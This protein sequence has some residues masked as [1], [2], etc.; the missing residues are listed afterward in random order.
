[1][2]KLIKAI[3]DMM[4]SSQ[5]NARKGRKSESFSRSEFKKLIQQEFAPV[6][7][8]AGALGGKRGWK[9]GLGGYFGVGRGGEES[10]TAKP[11]LGS[12]HS[13]IFQSSWSCCPR[14]PAGNGRPRV[15]KGQIHPWHWDWGILHPWAEGSRPFPT[16]GGADG[17]LSPQ[18]SPSSKYRSI[19]RP[20]EPDTEP[21]N[22]ERA[23][24][25][26]CVY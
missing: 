1:M 9:K 21:M 11:G 15:W 18:R 19:P 4:Q 14:F 22:K 13:L 24:A 3:T 7:V 5:G 17:L 20:S 12:L 26:S 16:S 25:K 2:S 6:K 8:T 23:P 10:A